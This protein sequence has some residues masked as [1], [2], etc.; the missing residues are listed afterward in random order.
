MTIIIKTIVGSQESR[1]KKTDEELTIEE[2]MAE[3]YDSDSEV[4]NSG[5][6]E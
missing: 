4:A 1:A 2:F 5:E 3:D 6:D